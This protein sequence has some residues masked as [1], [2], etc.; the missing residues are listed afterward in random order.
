MSKGEKKKTEIR[1]LILVFRCSDF[2][3]FLIN[4]QNIKKFDAE[5][6]GKYVG[7]ITKPTAPIRSKSVR[8]G[9]FST[10]FKFNFI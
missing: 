10:T 9:T 8:G 5:I 3:W 4:S 6:C 2:E 7:V 1:E